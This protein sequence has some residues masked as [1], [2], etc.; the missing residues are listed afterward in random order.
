MPTA[1][2]VYDFEGV[3]ER[4]I[5]AVFKSNGFVCATPL[6]ITKLQKHRPRFEVVF[7]TGSSQPKGP[8]GQRQIDSSNVARDVAWK[9]EFAVSIVTNTQET[10]K[11]VQANYR[12][13]CRYL[14]P[15]LGFYINGG[16]L[17]DDNDNLVSLQNHKINFV[18]ETS[19]SLVFANQDGYW[20][21]NLG[22]AIDFS[23]QSYAIQNLTLS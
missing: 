15:T 3:F 7:K 12:A 19:T 8:S 17:T 6:T 20:T 10:D 4:A 22:Y 2:Q 9:G 21:T 13:T 1:L 23:I 18:T 14:M 16:S 11:I 5:A